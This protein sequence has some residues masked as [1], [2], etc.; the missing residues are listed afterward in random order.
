MRGGNEGPWSGGRRRG[1]EADEVSRQSRGRKPQRRRIHGDGSAGA[2]VRDQTV[3]ELLS[4]ILAAGEAVTLPEP[5]PVSGD[6][7]VE[8][9]GRVIARYLPEMREGATRTLLGCACLG[10]GILGSYARELP[11]WLTDSSEPVDILDIMF[12][13]ALWPGRLRSAVEFAN[14]R[15]AWL[16]AL[17]SHRH[18]GDVARL[19]AITL[20][21]ARELERPVDD[22]LTWMGTILRAGEAGA[23]TRPLA[24]ALLPAR[25]L[26]GHRSLFGPQ[27]A[28]PPALLPGAAE[29][30]PAFI[31]FLPQARDLAFGSADTAAEALRYGV[32]ILA[33]ALLHATVDQG[34]LE[35][36]MA[37]MD[38]AP[39]CEVGIL[40]GDPDLVRAT[41]AFE[42]EANELLRLTGP[43]E[44]VRG[45][46]DDLPLR[47][48]VDR[49]SPLLLLGAL[50][51]GLSGGQPRGTALR[52]ALPWALGLPDSSPLLPITDVLIG[53]A[54]R[55]A[56][57]DDAGLDDAGS[58]TG[59][60]DTLGRVLSL[61]Q[62]DQPVLPGDGEWR[63]RPGVAVAAV[64]MRAGVREVPFDT[65]RLVALDQT[66]GQ[67]LRA[68]AEAFELTFG[69]PPGP[70]DP[71]FFDP[72]Q[73]E[74]SALTLDRYD[75][76][77]TK[78]LRSL[79]ASPLLIAAARLA[80]M[81]PP[82]N[83][84]FPND[85]MQRDWEAAIVAAGKELGLSARGASVQARADLDRLA[86]A[87]TVHVL[88]QAAD[89]Q[90]MG[91]CLLRDLRHAVDG[92][93]PDEDLDQD[94]DGV[95]PGTA[96]I[97]N[98]LR[99]HPELTRV[100]DEQLPDPR[101]AIA[102]ARAWADAPL[103]GQVRDLYQ[104]LPAPGHDQ[105]SDD[106]ADD[107]DA[108]IDWELVPAAACLVAAA[109]V[110]RGGPQPHH[111]H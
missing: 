49:M 25:L 45:T 35:L 24:S 16:R 66:S 28:S 90:Q 15:D 44:A 43:A 6:A 2:A 101:A 64:A 17:E 22:P 84:R 83:G 53:L 106:A 98:T 32:G 50:R 77:P 14:A 51:V 48:V 12:L 72:D 88:R 68:Q 87:S 80:Q 56:G 89:D 54:G 11:D 99:R 74:P 41:D 39:D 34:H 75:E 60:L 111:P 78:A 82:M 85:A 37:P 59:G 3:V 58:R 103:A 67:L 8:Q 63:G 57:H 91:I 55:Q 104:T 71:L 20:D 7:M 19:V 102:L 1:R 26:P 10:Y 4:E 76:A 70:D 27:E 31:A 110:G 46:V 42:A 79:G 97:A 62:A 73:D 92:A 94:L 23:G 105:A 109:A 5:L 100:A 47:A 69:R 36:A 95:S 93:D 9:S 33:S 107:L 38:A 108:D 65:G 13:G 86:V 61:P 96:A 21:A 52:Q 81:D 40:T 18:A 30:V 29:R